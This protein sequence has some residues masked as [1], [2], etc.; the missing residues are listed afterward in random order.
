MNEHELTSISIPAALNASKKKSPV[1]NEAAKKKK[2]RQLLNQSLEGFSKHVDH[3]QESLEMLEGKGHF[4][5]VQLC[6]LQMHVE[7]NTATLLKGFRKSECVLM[8][9]ET[10]VDDLSEHFNQFNREAKT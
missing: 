3:V 9:L 1:L 10:S 8:D 6:C 2:Q 7:E 4:A 5:V